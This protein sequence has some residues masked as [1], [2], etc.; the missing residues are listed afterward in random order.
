MVMLDHMVVEPHTVLHSDCTN[1]HSHQQ[2]MK[3]SFSLHTLQ[4]LVLDFLM[5]EKRQSLQQEVL[6]KLKNKSMK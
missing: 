2:C 5:M 3:V 4:H 6:E 1:L